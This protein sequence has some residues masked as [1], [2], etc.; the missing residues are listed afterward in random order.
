[1]LLLQTSAHDSCAPPLHSAR[2]GFANA[3]VCFWPVP[4]VSSFWAFISRWRTESCKSFNKRNS[5]SLIHIE[6][7][8]QVESGGMVLVAYAA[9][10]RPSGSGGMVLVAYA[11][12]ESTAAVLRSVFYLPPFP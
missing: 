7:F 8:V 1:M 6:S 5:L 10:E 4:L 11:A 12:P 3:G 9:A 2:Q